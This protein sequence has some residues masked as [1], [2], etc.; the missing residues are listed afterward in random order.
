MC[1]IAATLGER[2]S[3]YCRSNCEM[4]RAKCCRDGEI[5]RAPRSER[6]DHLK[7]NASMTT[8]GKT[9]LSV[10]RQTSEAIWPNFIENSSGEIA[11]SNFAIIGRNR[12]LE[13]MLLRSEQ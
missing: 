2:R 8:D 6:K 9:Q 1:Q 3:R 4:E 12:K 10:N 7:R 5:M 13:P 11:R